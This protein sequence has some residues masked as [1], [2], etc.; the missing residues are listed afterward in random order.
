MIIYIFILPLLFMSVLGASWF[1]IHMSSGNLFALSFLSCHSHSVRLARF[2]APLE[3]LA[4]R[5]VV[6]FLFSF[7]FST[8]AYHSSLMSPEVQVKTKKEDFHPCKPQR[9]SDEFNL[10]RINHKLPIFAGTSTNATGMKA[11]V[12]CGMR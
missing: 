3:P 6:V 8:S 10:T 5:W 4:T 9:W 1:P 2:P 12:D 11:D 7:F